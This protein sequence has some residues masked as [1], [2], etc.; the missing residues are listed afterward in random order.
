VHDVAGRRV[1]IHNV[2]V[3]GPGEHTLELDPTRSLAAGIYLVTL[4]D[5]R[6]LRSTKAVVVR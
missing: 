6:H 5:G 2:G 4:T 3:L 1:A